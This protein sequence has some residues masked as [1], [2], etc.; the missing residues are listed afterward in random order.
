MGND[1]ISSKE[2]V[3]RETQLKILRDMFVDG[4]K[5]NKSV[6]KPQVHEE[7]GIFFFHV[8]G[9]AHASIL[10]LKNDKSSKNEITVIVSLFTG[11]K[12]NSAVY[13]M[14]LLYDIAAQYERENKTKGND[15]TYT[16]EISLG[17]NIAYSDNGEILTG[18]EAEKQYMQKTADTIIKNYLEYAQSE[19]DKMLYDV[20]PQGNA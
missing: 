15:V 20:K 14:W 12:P 1:N 18:E 4:I 13:F 8:P 5:K 7:D 3:K 11:V 16:V 10:F 9:Y 6:Q 17:E 2:N 19:A